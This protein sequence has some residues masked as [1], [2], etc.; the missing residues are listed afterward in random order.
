MGTGGLWDIFRKDGRRWRFVARTRDP[1][2]YLT[3]PGRWR[4]D[5]VARGAPKP[6]DVTKANVS[7]VPPKSS[8]GK[9]TGGPVA[10]A[11]RCGPP[12]R[13]RRRRA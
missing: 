6:L 7:E 8:R 2:R 9:L 13:S 11:L 12:D 5:A 3:R 10:G 4:A 1:D